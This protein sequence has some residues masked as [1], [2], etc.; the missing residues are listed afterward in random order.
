[1]RKRSNLSLT[2]VAFSSMDALLPTPRRIYEPGV[3]IDQFQISKHIGKG[4]YGDIYLVIDINNNKPYAMK[5][6][7]KTAQKQGLLTEKSFF[8]RIQDSNLFPTFIYYGSNS[9][10]RFLVME[11][12]GPSLSNLRR[13]LPN[14]RYTINTVCRLS[15]HMLKCIQEFHKLGCIHRDIK[16]GN[17]LIRPKRENPVCLIDYG[18]SRVY[19]NENG[20]HLQPRESVGFTGTCKYASIH[21]HQNM[22]L[23]RR[24]DLISWFYSLIELIECKVPWPGSKNRE[25]TLVMK[26]NATPEQLCRSLPPQYIEILKIIGTME[27]YTEPNYDRIIMLIEEAIDSSG[28]KEIPMDYEVLPPETVK[29]FSNIPLVP[30]E[31]QINQNTKAEISHPY[32]PELSTPPQSIHERELSPPQSN[33]PQLE[34]PKPED[35][36][37]VS[38]GTTSKPLRE[39][40]LAVNENIK[41]T[42]DKQHKNKNQNSK[43]NK[44]KKGKQKKRKQNKKSTHNDESESKEGACCIVF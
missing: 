31:D 6:E 40:N 23:S 4:G 43:K 1:M 21:A 19:L 37:S 9:E 16:P 2:V 33:T 15:Y 36:P 26:Q 28:G 8:D 38:D 25:K 41:D 14:R 10:C 22:E 27:Y 34:I 5:V 29:I 13:A 12:L 7:L 18:L 20:E 32:V 17:F 35:V 39:E 42:P 44:K 30:S 24:D 11:L 3:I